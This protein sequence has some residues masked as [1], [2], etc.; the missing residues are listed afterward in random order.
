MELRN[1]CLLRVGWAALEGRRALGTDERS[2]GYGGT[3][4]KSTKGRFE[5]PGK[6]LFFG[7]IR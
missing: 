6:G 1:E 7:G 3:G 5:P 2:F 4:M